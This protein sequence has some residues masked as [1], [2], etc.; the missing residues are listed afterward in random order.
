MNYIETIW[1]GFRRLDFTFEGR[2][3]ILVCPPTS[4]EEAAARN[5]KQELTVNTL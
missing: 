3:A 5:A 2:E 4:G 1:N